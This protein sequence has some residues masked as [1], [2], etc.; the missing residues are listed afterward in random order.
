MTTAT[1]TITIDATGKRLGRLA[2]SIAIILNGK[3][4][5][6]YAPNKVPNVQ[7]EVENVSQLHITE[8]KKK[9]K[10]YQ[11]YTG[12]FGGLRTRTLSDLIDKKGVGEALRKAVYG[13]L[14]ANRIRN[15]KMK[16]LH[17]KE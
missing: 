3:N 15:E 17:I 6:E 4:T 14:P 12:H 9:Q 5:P 10:T 2:S 11:H 8:K 1:E 16:R 13:M 7:V